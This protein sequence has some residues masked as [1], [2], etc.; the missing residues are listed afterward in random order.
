MQDSTEKM[1]FKFYIWL[2]RS[3]SLGAIKNFWGILA[4]PISFQGSINLNS[5]PLKCFKYPIDSYK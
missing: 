2:A 4:H 3:P 1:L 5:L